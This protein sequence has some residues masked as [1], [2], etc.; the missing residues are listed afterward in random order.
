MKRKLGGL[1]EAAQKNEDQCRQVER[2]CL[3]RGLVR[4]DL[5]KVVAARD[6]AEDEH[7][8]DQG[9]SAHAGHGERHD[10]PLPA[11]RQVF[12]VADEQE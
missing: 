12:P 8:A 3:H 11:F 5:G 9:Q 4:K 7:T 10:G 2:A 1:G 6:L